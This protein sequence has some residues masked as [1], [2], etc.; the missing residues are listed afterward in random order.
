MATRDSIVNY[1][2]SDGVKTKTDDK[3]SDGLKSLL[4]ATLAK[5][6]TP[7]KRN[8]TTSQVLTHKGLTTGII[9]NAQTCDSYGKELVIQDEHNLYSF[10]ESQASWID[11]GAGVNSTLKKTNIFY[12]GKFDELYN[13]TVAE[14]GNIRVYTARILNTNNAVAIV[15][16]NL[17]ESIILS[18]EFTA[19]KN[20]VAFSTSTEIGFI[21]HA[22]APINAL[23]FAKFVPATCTLDID[24]TLLTPG[25]VDANGFFDVT[26]KGDGI[27]VAWFDG[28]NSVQYREHSNDL[29]TVL[30]SGST[31]AGIAGNVVKNGPMQISYESL[32]DKVFLSFITLDGVNHRAYWER[33]NTDLTTDIA[34]V[35]YRTVDTTAGESFQIVTFSVIADEIFIFLTTHSAVSFNSSRIFKFKYTISTQTQIIS[36]RLSYQIMTASKSFVKNGKV[37]LIAALGDSAKTDD[38]MTKVFVMV[39]F[40]ENI[41]S[42][43]LYD[44]ALMPWNNLIGFNSFIPQL[45]INGD[46]VSCPCAEIISTD[47]SNVRFSSSKTSIVGIDFKFRSLDRSSGFVFGKSLILPGSCPK[48]YDGSTVFEYGFNHRAHIDEP[49]VASAGILNG[50]YL[51]IL[52]YEYIDSNGVVHV[53]EPSKIATTV[54]ALVNEQN[55]LDLYTYKIGTLKT[56]CK[57]HLYRTEANSSEVFYRVTPIEGIDNDYNSTTI[58]FVDNNSDASIVDNDTYYFNGGV[59]SPQAAPPFSSATIYNNRLSIISD[60]SYNETRYTQEF[61]PNFMGMFNEFF[62]IGN[63]ENNQ[64][65]QDLIT[66]NHTMDDKL[67]IFKKNSLSFVSGN[68]PNPIGENDNFSRPIL[69]SSDAGCINP[70]SVVSMPLGLMFESKKGIY[71][72]SRNLEVIYIGQDVEDK[73]LS[74]ITGSFLHENIHVVV[75]TQE[76]NDAIVYDYLHNKWSNFSNYSANDCTYWKDKIVHIKTDGTTKI[77]N[78]NFDDD[79]L[80]VPFKLVTNWLKLSGIQAFQRIKRILLIG[81]YKSAHDL[82]ISLAYN[83]QEYNWQEQTY[84]PFDVSNY[85]RTTK[86]TSSELYTG[87]NDGPYQVKMTPEKQKCE[88]V[89]VTIED[90]ETTEQGESFELTNLSFLIGRKKGTYKTQSE[91]RT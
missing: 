39:D 18:Q 30:N 5:K 72:L 9:D 35:S 43:Y 87:D 89:M 70:R 53:S 49:I 33:R 80:F 34:P 66:V 31:T 7:R 56:K 14:L 73:L 36:T 13:L 25:T 3:L 77:E 67:I 65:S 63:E 45:I 4:N 48:I 84:S 74:S 42:R 83:Y 59:L 79:G 57:M 86:P 47:L 75:F 6:N 58:S 64:S 15:Y 24:I 55:T 16:D 82:K 29:Q 1:S 11:K 69:I 37:Y 78:A 52:I 44:R 90:I 40:E 68:G 41:Y 50:V 27:I 32:S 54:V 19:G 85:N 51:Y 76:N 12:D 61:S 71:L 20:L 23:K 62:R 46:D 60:D 38:T 22:A 17:S 21:F 8:G 26:K 91:K 88:S 81:K 28:T 10:S 2:L